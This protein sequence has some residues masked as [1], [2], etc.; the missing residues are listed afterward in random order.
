MLRPLA[1]TFVVPGIITGDHEFYFDAPCD[2]TL[3]AVSA[4]NKTASNGGTV[5]VGTSGDKDGYL[6][7][8]AV[9]GADAT[10]YDLDDF[11]GALVTNQGD[12]YPHITAGTTMYVKLIDGETSPTDTVIVLWFEEG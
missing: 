3:R 10:I 4:G 7:G 8:V 1:V 12:D 11:N 2:L 6:D 9:G 5:D